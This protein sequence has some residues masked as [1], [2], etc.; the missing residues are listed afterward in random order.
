MKIV[1]FSACVEVTTS[2]PSW[3]RTLLV[4]SMKSPVREASSPKPSLLMRQVFGS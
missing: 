3:Y 4:A 1:A 2:W